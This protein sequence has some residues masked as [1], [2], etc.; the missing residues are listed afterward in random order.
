MQRIPTLDGQ[1]KPWDLPNLDLMRSF[2]VLTVLVAHTLQVNGVLRLGQWDVV[3]F[4]LFGVFLFFVHTCLVLMWSLERRPSTVDFYIRRAFRIY[5]LAIFV[6]FLILL[7]RIPVGGTPENLFVFPDHSFMTVISNLLL[8][9]NILHWK[10]IEAVMWSLPLEMQ[11]YIA[12]PM[13][14]VFA[15]K[16]RRI[17]PLFLLWILSVIALASNVGSNFGANTLT[18][19]PYF[20]PGA[21]A[22]IGFMHRKTQYPG[23]IFLPFIALLVFVFELHPSIGMG[24][25]ICLALGLA[26][27]SFRQVTNKTVTG[28]SH[29]LAKYSY[30]IYLMHPLAIALAFYYLPLRSLMAK[31]AVEI[32]CVVIFSFAGYHFVE[33][34]MIRFGSRVADRL[35]RS[36]NPL[37]PAYTLA[38]AAYQPDDAETI[39]S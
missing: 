32:V 19:V 14:F 24:W 10:N 9:Q 30:G 18:V 37:D 23:W 7:F 8:M 6:I 5:P 16:E 34:P 12:L 17:W 13:L 4:G 33:F 25:W 39:G 15:R 38:S 36:H 2:A 21:M 22:Y 31:L 20:L 35:R 28:L 29:M 27:P 26:L 3:W 11:M 1:R